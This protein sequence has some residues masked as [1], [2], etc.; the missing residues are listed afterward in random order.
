MSNDLKKTITEELDRRIGNLKEHQY[1]QIKVT[2]NQYEELNQALSKVIGVP[3]IK[4]LENVRKFV[5]EL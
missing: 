2:G 4:E 5:Q 3:L 1:D